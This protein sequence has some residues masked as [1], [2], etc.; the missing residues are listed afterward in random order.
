MDI[1]PARLAA[2]PADPL[3][4]IL[5]ADPAP[6]YA[7]LAATRPIFFDAAL[8]W[9]VAASADVVDA[10]LGST[11]CRVRP[12]DEPV[13][14]AV[15]AS[16]TG[17][18]F[19]RLVRQIDGPDHGARKATV[20][21]ALGRLDISALAARAHRQA[22]AALPDTA[23]LDAALGADAHFRVPLAT[24]A[25]T[26]LADHADT[27][28]CQTDIAAYLAALGPGASPSAVEH[29]DAAVGRLQ[30]R[31][32]GS[33]LATGEDAAEISNLAALLAQTYDACAGLL[34]NCIVTLSRHPELIERL[35]AQ[36]EAV[37]P[38]VREVLRRDAPV[39]NTRRF[40]AHDTE[41]L[42]Q[43]V[44]AGDRILVLL[45]AANV[46]AAVNPDPLRFDIDRTRPRLWT[47]GAG[48]HRCPAETLA[49]VI[50][51]E[52]VQH[53]LNLHGAP[54]WFAR[55]GETT[56]VTYRPSPNARIPV[57]SA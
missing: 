55:L 39:Q 41:V 26:L 50:A 31:F 51:R 34:G 52:T 49:V 3:Q 25:Q 14:K 17:A 21:A 54:R 20:M 18:F 23:S 45:A 43:P 35:R 48:V 2:P 7:G 10:V 19:S 9:W 36:S 15:A 11:A 30:Q 4:A 1:A 56:E 40:V 12:V 28:A 16:P 5:H 47:F 32:A 42:G 38:F 44:R 22:Y 37:E 33:R 8:G 46:D 24:I 57:F 29:A 27:Q 6:Y 13:P 53:L